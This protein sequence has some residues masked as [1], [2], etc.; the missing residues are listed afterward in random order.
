MSPPKRTILTSEERREEVKG[1]VWY[2]A[3]P[4]SFCHWP[5]SKTGEKEIPIPPQAQAIIHATPD[6]GGWLCGISTRPNK[7][8]Y[9]AVK[10]AGLNDVRIHDLRHS[11]ASVALKQGY[12]LSQIGA[13]LGHSSTQTTQRYAHLDDKI[14]REAMNSIADG[15]IGID[16]KKI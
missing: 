9:K 16:N 12:T 3:Q 14:K 4:F 6:N 15:I 5:D 1:C 11:F 13:L 8:W 2:E 10:K 7:A